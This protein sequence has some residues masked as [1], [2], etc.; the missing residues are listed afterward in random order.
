MSDTP[1]DDPKRSAARVVEH[2]EKFNVPVQT[3]QEDATVEHYADPL[4]VKRKKEGLD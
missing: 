1:H 3:E 2:Q 4:E